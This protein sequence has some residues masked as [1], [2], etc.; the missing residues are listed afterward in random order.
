MNDRLQ[1]DFFV[2]DWHVHPARCRLSRDG[3]TTPV[4]PKV[5][6]LLVYLAQAPGRVVSKDALLNDVW[7]T[8][9]VSE[10]AL[11]R[12]VAELRQALGDSA[13]TPRIL[14]TI[15]KRGYRL[16]APVSVEHP[17]RS[18]DVPPAK[19]PQTRKRAL[20]LAPVV[21]ALFAGPLVW[22]GASRIAPRFATLLGQRPVLPFTARE[23]VLIAPFENRTGEAMFEQ[24]V[25][26]ALEQELLDSGFVNVVPRPRVEDVLALMKKAPDTRL[27]NG[28]AREVAVRDGGIRVLLTGYIH[29]VRGVYVLTTSVVN[30]SDGRTLATV[31]HDAANTTE[32]LPAVRRQALDVRET[33]GDV[34]GAAE[35]RTDYLARVTTSS[36]QA[37]QLYSKAAALLNGE[38]WRFHPDAQSRY[39]SA[40]ALLT[41]AT[42]LDPSFASAWLLLAHAMC[43][44]HRPSG[45]YLPIAERALELTSGVS[46]AERYFIE[47]F[48]LSRR[49]RVSEQVRDYEAAARA[50]ETVLQLVPDHY[51]TL[52]ELVPVYRQLGRFDDAARLVIHGAEVRP[53]SVRFA[54]DAARVHLRRGERTEARAMIERATLLAKEDAGNVAAVPVDSLQWLRLWEAHEAWLDKDPT[55]A[56]VAARRVEKE[57][58]GDTSISTSFGIAYVYAGLGRYEDALRVA[59]RLPEHRRG[60]VRDLFAFQRQRWEDLRHVFEPQRRDFDLLNS[61]LMLLAWGNRF[62]EA[63]WVLAERQRRRLRYPADAVA[64]HI[65]QLRIEQGRYAE[66]LAL[67]ERLK[68]DPMGPRYY[69]VEHI[70]MARRG[71]EDAASAIRELERAGERRAEP[72][73]F[74]AWQVY[75]WLRC[76][77]LLF[78]LYRDAGR[79]ADAEGVARDVRTLL[80]L[81]DADHPLLVRVSRMTAAAGN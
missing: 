46:V 34:I 54:V 79:H 66:G 27:D 71:L 23:W 47:G 64:D 35:R 38:I 48:A 72:V 53:R 31:S 36:L 49:A 9:A 19:R 13:E 74:D 28:L 33:L 63:E 22:G 39:A 78:E 5:M 58:A 42:A 59:E 68:P 51:W 8:D 25:E 21:V 50:Y 73:A 61:R 14:E 57:S 41:Q 2:G 26:Q 30:P 17:A 37:L 45:E 40:E 10:S 69:V 1:G 12:T 20:V 67:L 6:D 75:S 56:L 3:Q 43:Q 52:L 15:P 81:A 80:Q 16:I 4:R 65:G 60:W 18:A 62:A 32:L 44:Q 29:R 77:V 76:R 24:V 70:A 7:G 55:R 11:T